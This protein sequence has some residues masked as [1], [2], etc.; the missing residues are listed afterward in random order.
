[1]N[2]NQNE[3]PPTS[4]TPNKTQPVTHEQSSPAQPPQIVLESGKM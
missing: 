1:M 4:P 2:Q 3:G